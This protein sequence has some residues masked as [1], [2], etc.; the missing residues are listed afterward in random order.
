[1]FQEFKD[2]VVLVTGSNSGIGEETVVLFASYGAKVVV[3]G[4]NELRINNVTSKCQQKSPF[5]YEPLKVVA[6]L[7]KEEDVK[8][9]VDQT[10]NKFG[11]LDV[12]VN[13]AAIAKGS[14][15]MDEDVLQ[16]FDETMAF[17]LRPVVHLCHLCLPHLVESKGVIVNVSSFAGSKPFGIKSLQ[18]PIFAT[19]CLAKAGLDMLTKILAVEFGPK[20]VRVNCVSPSTIVTPMLDRLGFSEE[21]KL[22][23]IANQESSNLLRRIGQPDD[24]STIILF[25][26]S[27]MSKFLTGIVMLA[28]GGLHLI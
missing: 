15:I 21:M 22:Q 20:G 4:R 2:K 11:R 13:C 14:N 6:D 3:T 16:K 27:N 24:I 26:A 17:N 9:L 10:I 5:N 28:D 12:L 23:I 1:M 18:I 8:S 25:F 7:V 19:Y